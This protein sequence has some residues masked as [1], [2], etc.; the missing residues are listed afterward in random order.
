MSDRPARAEIDEQA[1]RDGLQIAA[2]PVGMEGAHRL[3]GTGGPIR[4]G[5]LRFACRKAS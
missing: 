5:G 3:I 1:L 2:E 4:A